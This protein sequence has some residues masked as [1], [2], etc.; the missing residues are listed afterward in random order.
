MGEEVCL[1]KMCNQDSVDE[2]SMGVKELTRQ[3]TDDPDSLGS[4]ISHS[5]VQ[6]N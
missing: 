3:D 2:C 1:A 6:I 4:S 5:P